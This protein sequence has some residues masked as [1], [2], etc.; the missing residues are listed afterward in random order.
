[1]VGKL[2]S[3][4]A[5]DKQVDE[6]KDAI[7]RAQQSVTRAE[8]EHASNQRDHLQQL[9]DTAIQSSPS[10][11]AVID[12]AQIFNTVKQVHRGNRDLVRL[13]EKA[14]REIRQAASAVSSAQTMEMFDL[15]SVN[16]GIS[17]MSSVSNMS[18]GS[19]MDDAR[20]AVKAFAQAAQ[21]HQERVEALSHDTTLEVLDLGLDLFDVT[22]WFDIGSVL[23]LMSLSSASSA[24]SDAERKVK[25]MLEPLKRAEQN[26]AQEYRR[27]REA[28]MNEKL[29]IFQP[30][31]RAIQ[32]RGLPT[33]DAKLVSQILETHKID[34]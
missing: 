11:S 1:M 2:T 32:A 33:P 28:L 8:R 20:R 17:V 22:G 15:A 27:D 21:R 26:S 31:I 6:L 7:K 13:G 9:L 12:R 16:K 18:A 4:W 5:H 23:S 3:F 34:L 10:R 29:E 30:V 14:L 25:Q 24:L 19:E